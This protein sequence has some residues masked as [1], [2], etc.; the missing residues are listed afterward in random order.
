MWPLEALL[1][2]ALA[3]TIDALT[4]KFEGANKENLFLAFGT[5]IVDSVIDESRNVSN[6]SSAV[7]LQSFIDLGKHGG[8]HPSLSLMK[9]TKFL[10]VVRGERQG[11]TSSVLRMMVR[12]T[13]QSRN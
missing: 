12:L 3:K 9:Q 10:V 13:K 8:K 5:F 4:F 2:R 11:A 7:A 6:N 1:S